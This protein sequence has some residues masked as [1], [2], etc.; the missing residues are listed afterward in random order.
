MTRLVGCGRD[1]QLLLYGRHLF[2]FLDSHIRLL[3]HAWTDSTR[4]WIVQIGDHQNGI[5]HV[6]RA[7]RVRRIR[8]SAHNR[9][10]R[11]RIQREAN[12]GTAIGDTYGDG[13][14]D[15][16]IQMAIQDIRMTCIFHKD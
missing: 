16:G 14:A 1:G 3:H 11:T 13:R 8:V 7:T 5:G 12:G 9:Y 4:S 10:L 15:M 6:G 2:P